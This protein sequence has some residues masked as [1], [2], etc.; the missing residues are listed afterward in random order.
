M[1]TCIFRQ[2]FMKFTMVEFII[3]EGK[4]QSIQNLGTNDKILFDMNF[5]IK[6]QPFIYFN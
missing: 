4:I 5:K 3:I 6:S 2:I 1:K